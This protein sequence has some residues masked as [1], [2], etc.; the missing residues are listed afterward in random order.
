MKEEGLFPLSQEKRIYSVTE[1]TANIKQILESSFP[2]VWVEG[3]ISNLKETSSG[4]IYFILKD[5]FSQ[6]KVVLFRNFL[7]S[8]KFRLKNGLQIIVGGRISLYA[9]RGEYQLIAESVEP[10]GMG[11]LQL[12]LEQLKEKLYKEGLFAPEKKKPLPSFFNRIALVTSP[13][14][15]AVRDMIKI[16]TQSFPGIEI[17]I[18]PVKVQGEEAPWEICYALEEINRMGEVDAIIL[19]RGGGSLEDLW[20]FNEEMV[21]RSIFASKIPVISAVGHEID[22]TIADMVADVRAPTPSAAA[23]LVVSIMEKAYRRVKE[24]EGKIIRLLEEKIKENSQRLKRLYSGLILLHPLRNLERKRKEAETLNARL[25][26]VF[27]HLLHIQ[28]EKWRTLAGKLHSLSP[29]N[30]LERGY[31]ITYLLPSQVIVRDSRQAKKGDRLKVKVCKGE[32]YCGVE[33]IEVS[34]ES[35]NSH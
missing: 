30:V 26:E 28:R 17:L 27:S 13:S 1:L 20:A 5:A 3:E 22:Y 8:L 24:N 31:S 25:K 19:G 6:L 15:A 2:F 21:A 9:E 29:L 35:G 32:I 23:E 12:A 16:I 4:H 34:N 10:K 7:S 33:S 14:G 11:S 18:Y